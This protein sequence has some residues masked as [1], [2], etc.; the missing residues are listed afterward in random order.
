MKVYLNASEVAR[1]LKVDRATVTRW[2]Q[3]GKLKGAVRIGKDHQW[4]IPFST[5]EELLI[6]EQRVKP[7]QPE[8]CR[9]G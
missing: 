1:L 9:P 4:R 2:A 6:L 8:R 3:Q 5:Y 7:A